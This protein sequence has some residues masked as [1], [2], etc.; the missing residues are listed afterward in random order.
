MQ[1]EIPMSK[2]KQ[3]RN[4]RTNYLT[5]KKQSNLISSKISLAPHLTCEQKVFVL[6]VH[7]TIQYD[8]I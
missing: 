3:L 2:P 1:I 4:I 8:M 5:R 7:K 6:S